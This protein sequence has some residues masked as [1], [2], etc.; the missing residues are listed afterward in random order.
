MIASCFLYY[1]FINVL[2]IMSRVKLERYCLVTVGATVGFRGLTSVVLQPP[3]WHFLLANGF[4]NLHVQCGPDIEWASKV[5]E[6]SKH[7]APPNLNI[8]VFDVRKNLLK[9]EMILCK[10]VSGLR[11]QGL[12]ISH[13]GQ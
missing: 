5:V 12:V 7:V 4:T 3:F 9:E 13:A 2:F 1:F 11:A 6:S 10:P 8:N